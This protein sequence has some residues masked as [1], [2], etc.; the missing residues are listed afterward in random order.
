MPDDKTAI[1]KQTEL[2]RDLDD[3]VL[4]VLAKHSVVKHLQ[5]DEILFL[6]GELAK[7]LYVI[8]SGAVRAFRTSH[9]GREQVTHV[10]R[11]V[12][13][14]A[15]VPVFDDGNYPSNVTAEEPS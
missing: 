14:I 1:F 8:A 5:R 11:A 7:G 10:E 13:T 12:A 3:A 4:D 6:A 9:D 2:F 15:A